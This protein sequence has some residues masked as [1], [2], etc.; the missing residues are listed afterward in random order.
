MVVVL[1]T[2]LVA[3]A[4]APAGADRGLDRDADDTAGPLDIARIVHKHR[5]GRPNVFVHKIVMHDRWTNRA[6]SSRHDSRHITVTFDVRRAGYGCIGCISEREVVI[7]SQ[8]GRVQAT[9]YNH[10]GDPPRKL[11]DLRVWRPNDRSVAFAVRKRQLMRK[12]RDHYQWG[13][14]TTYQ[15]RGDEDCPPRRSCFDYAPRRRELLRH[16]L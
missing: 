8:E 13:V 4:P 5:K 15:R 16:Q 10:L 11:A 2:L 9:L 14:G 1:V 7:T 12:A 3:M 6:I